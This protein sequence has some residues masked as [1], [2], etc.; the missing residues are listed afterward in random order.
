MEVTSFR[1]CPSN[2]TS[3]KK[4]N[5][6]KSQKKTEARTKARL[7]I[8]NICCQNTTPGRE[9]AKNWNTAGRKKFDVTFKLRHIFVKKI[10][11]TSKFVQI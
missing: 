8:Q 3:F 1:T 7:A 4:E 10:I 2:F 11:F 6:Q 5:N 9:Y